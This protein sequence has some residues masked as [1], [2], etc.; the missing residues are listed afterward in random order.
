M[1]NNTCYMFEKKSYKLFINLGIIT[2][3]K[4]KYSN[5][6]KNH[7]SKQQDE[8]NWCMLEETQR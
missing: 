6:N 3:L 2:S 1:I 5:W 7:A 4:I 8:L